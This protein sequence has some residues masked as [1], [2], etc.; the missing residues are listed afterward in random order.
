[1]A[2]FYRGIVLYWRVDT[3]IPEKKY[4]CYLPAGRSVLEKYFVEVSKTARDRRSRDVFETE[5]K[6]FSVRTNLN[7][8]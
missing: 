5:T 7:G 2:Y 1:M 6:Y 8:K 3:I 4:I